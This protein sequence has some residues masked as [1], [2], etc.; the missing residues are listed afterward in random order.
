MEWQDNGI[1]LKLSP[2]GEGK[3]VVSIFTQ[4]HGR[5]LGYIRGTRKQSAFLQPGSLVTCTWQ[6]RLEEQLGSWKLEPQRSLYSNL[7][8]KPICLAALLSACAWIEKTLA[9]REEH[10]KLY[11][12]FKYCLEN[13]HQADGLRHYVHFETNLLQ[14]LG[15]G[16]DFSQCAV[17]GQKEDLQYVSPRTG[18][19]VCAREGEAFKSRLLAFPAFLGNNHENVP[20]KDIVDGLQL[21]GYFLERFVLTQLNKAMPE[22][23]LRLFQIL[24]KQING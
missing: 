23:R 15:F 13:I 17:S 5:H 2:H 4:N 11:D 8:G 3:A 1:I 12:T 14:E 18:K 20:L 22:A 19:A 21:T 7:M 9:E 24:R 16:L 6:S 10:P